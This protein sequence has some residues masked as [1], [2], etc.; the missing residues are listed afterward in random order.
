MTEM[1]PLHLIKITTLLALLLIFMPPIQAQELETHCAT[2]AVHN[3][4]RKNSQPASDTEACLF[5][6]GHKDLSPSIQISREGVVFIGKTTGGVLRSTDNGRSWSDISIPAH[7]NGDSHRGT[8]GYIHIDPKTNR[9]YYVTS[10]FAASCKGIGGAVISWSDDLGETWDGS[11]T[12]CDTFDWGRLVT[13]VGPAGGDQRAVYFLGVAP[14]LIGGLRPVYR[15]L[16]GGRTWT[17]MKQFASVTTEAGAAVTASDGT[18]YFDY[19]EFTGFYPQRIKNLDYPY[20]PENKCRAMIAVS[21]D[22]GETWRQQ[23][24]PGSQACNLL[25]GQQ[26]V[27]VDAAGTVY[28]VWNDDRDGQ[29]YLVTSRDKGRSWSEPLNVMP[30]DATFNNSYAN[31]VAG[32]A[33]H[34]VIAAM[35]TKSSWNPRIGILQGL[36][37]W[38]S[39]LTSSDNADSALPLFHSINLDSPTDPSLKSG[40]TPTEA[41]AY[42]GISSTGDTWAVFARHGKFP[43]GAGAEINAAHITQ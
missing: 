17:R 41:D 26:R 18:I 30:P 27:A 23:A 6:T 21:E 20:K 35:N 16:D 11:T 25:F 43:L 40:Q 28:A 39:Y 1:K 7:A 15:S 38:N 5:D 29:V 33:G 24:I 36:G 12:G 19:P 14:R 13:G 8:H 2:G 42:L 31:I 3:A 9:I 37:K 4:D 22:F 10:L 34:I 32:D